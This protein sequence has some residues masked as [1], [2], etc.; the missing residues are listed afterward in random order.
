MAIESVEN[1]GFSGKLI[2][3]VRDVL[4]EKVLDCFRIKEYSVVNTF[5]Y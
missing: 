3:T 2:L 1:K 5:K 4:L